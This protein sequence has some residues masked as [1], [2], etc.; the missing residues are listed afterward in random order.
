MPA[1]LRPHVIQPMLDRDQLK[2]L[3]LELIDL[4]REIDLMA[5]NEPGRTL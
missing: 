1:T 2:S 5:R 3:Q 4:L